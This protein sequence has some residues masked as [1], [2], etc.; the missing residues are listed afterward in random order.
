MTVPL[1]SCVAWGK[2]TSLSG[3]QFPCLKNEDD[4]TNPNTYLQGRHKN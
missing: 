3:P 4:S 2:L 1:T